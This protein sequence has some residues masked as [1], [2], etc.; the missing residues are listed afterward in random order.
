M[1]SRNESWLELGQ[2]ELK[3]PEYVELLEDVCELV[4]NDENHP[5][6]LALDVFELLVVTV[7][8]AEEPKNDDCELWN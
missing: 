7:P 4:E 8:V 6:E 3:K 2:D 5:P 1:Q